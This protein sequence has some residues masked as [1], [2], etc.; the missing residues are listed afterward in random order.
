MQPAFFYMSLYPNFTMEAIRMH[1]M[2][3]QAI[4]AQGILAAS[5]A[6]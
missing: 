4:L 2:P 1:L 3:A 6:A 5:A